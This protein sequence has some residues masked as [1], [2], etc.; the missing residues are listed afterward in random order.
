MTRSVTDWSSA[1]AARSRTEGGGALK[2]ILR[3]ANAEGVISFAGGF[4]DPQTFPRGALLDGF[5][6]VVSGVDAAPLQYSPVAGLPGPRDFVASRIEQIDGRRPS[7]DEMLLT[8]GGIEALQL[9]NQ[10]LIESGDVVLVEAPT[11]LGAIMSFRNFGADLRSIPMDEG[12]LKTDELEKVLHRSRRPKLLYTIPDHQNPMGATLHLD[13]RRRLVELARRYGF[14]IVEDV[15]YR[16]LYFGP[17]PLPSFWAL[18]PDVTMQIGTFSKTFLPGFRLGW[19][20]G[21]AQLVAGMVNAKQLTDQCAGALGQCLLECYGRS[22]QM[23]SQVAR[24]RELYRRRRDLLLK[25]LDAHMPEGVSWTHPDGGFFTWLTLD[26]KADSRDLA[27]SARE[28][29][30]AFV[31]GAPF[32]PEDRGHQQLRLSFSCVAESQISDGTQRLAKLFRE[33]ALT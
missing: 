26:W 15:A 25:A 29:G 23:D 31:P 14:L 19:A 3:L 7:P 11:Y 10:T 5:R 18:G 20:A 4:P 17:G 27:V 9:L 33:S 8:S 21:P 12:G 24:S 32:F 22:G 2:E 16:E 13:R 28:R 1:F 30:V 6:D